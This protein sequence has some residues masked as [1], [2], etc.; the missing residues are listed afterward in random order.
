MSWD[1]RQVRDPV[2]NQQF[3][4]LFDEL[5]R[6]RAL[7]TGGAPHAPTHED[8]GT[9]PLDVTD[10]AGFPGGAGTFLRAD[11]TFAAPPGGSGNF[12]TATLDFGATPAEEASVVVIGQAG[13]IAGS[14]V[15]AF[16]QKD[17]TAGNGVDEHE[18]AGALCPLSVGSIVPGTGF[19]IFASPIAALGVGQFNVHWTWS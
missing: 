6:L 12:G 16:F 7:L 1:A 19:T 17:S 14:H 10:L 2:T 13:I 15:R 3:R 8:G 9:D 18:E 11:G 5:R 4:D